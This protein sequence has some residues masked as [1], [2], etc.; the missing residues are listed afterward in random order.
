MITD[1]NCLARYRSNALMGRPY[2]DGQNKTGHRDL[3]INE[4]NDFVN[5][6]TCTF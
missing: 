1:Q 3:L 6:S 4:K 2:P 5:A